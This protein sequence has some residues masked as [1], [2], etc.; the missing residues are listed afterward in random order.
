MSKLILLIILVISFQALSQSS[1]KRD[2]VLSFMPK[3][4]TELSKEDINTLSQKFQDKIVSKK[5]NSLFLNYNQPNDVTI[6][7]KN[8][9]F[10]YLLME[11]T[12]EMKEKATG[13]FGRVYSS[14]TKKEKDK[15]AKEMTRPTHD[16]GEIIAIDLISESV[17]LEFSNNEKK[18]L[19]RVII[20]PV[21]GERP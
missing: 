17:R 15:L 18:T 11:A 16:A 7:F 12:P 1:P 4:L 14:L 21:G 13:L 10:K 2:E 6:G 19:K 5:P 9:Q 3:E 8:Q 20:W